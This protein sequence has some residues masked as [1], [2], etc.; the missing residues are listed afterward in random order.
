LGES[1]RSTTLNSQH[2][3][4]GRNLEHLFPGSGLAPIITSHTSQSDMKYIEYAVIVRTPTT[5]SLLMMESHIAYQHQYYISKVKIGAP[6]S[7][8]PS[9]LT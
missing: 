6:V 2:I 4:L 5:L 7:I 3:P 8:L 9:N 1:E